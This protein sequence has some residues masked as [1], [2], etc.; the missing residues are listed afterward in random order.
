MYSWEKKINRLKASKLGE[1]PR[2]SKRKWWG[3]KGGHGGKYSKVREGTLEL[4]VAVKNGGQEK[5][6]WYIYIIY[7]LHMYI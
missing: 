3:V 4:K 6:V 1:G 7:I 5:R 2:D